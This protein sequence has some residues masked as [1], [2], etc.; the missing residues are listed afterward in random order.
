MVSDPK[1]MTTKT[2]KLDIGETDEAIEGLIEAMGI[3]S[4]EALQ[5]LD[6]WLPL[7]DTESLQ[8]MVGS[9][10]RLPSPGEPWS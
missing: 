8:T 6:T 3:L 9:L 10:A 7:C 2:L 4:P 5:N 1:P